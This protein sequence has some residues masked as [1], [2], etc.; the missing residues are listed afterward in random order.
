MARLRNQEVVEYYRND[1]PGG[2]LELIQ[3]T[4]EILHP[5]NWKA[6]LGYTY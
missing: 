1:S 3:D 2:M 4:I 5:L 6:Q